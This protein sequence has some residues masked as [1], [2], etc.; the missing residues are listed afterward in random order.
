MGSLF[1]GG[2]PKAST[3]P[4]ENLEADKTKAKKARTSLFATEGG[5][6]GAKLQDDDIK[7]RRSLLG[8]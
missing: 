2:A 7:E 1:G 4:V 6:L 8:N 3:A 5:V